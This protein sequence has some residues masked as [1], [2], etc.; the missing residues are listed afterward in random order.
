MAN[1][2]GTDNPET[3]DANDGVTNGADTIFGFGGDDT[4]FGLGGN[5]ELKG[6]GGA[7]TLN[8]GTPRREN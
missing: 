4:I 8:G 3:L 5:D 2:F 6:G 7:D 1:V